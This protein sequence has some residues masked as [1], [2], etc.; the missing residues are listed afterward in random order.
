MVYAAI[1]HL[2]LGHCEG[3]LSQQKGLSTANEE[4]RQG[5]CINGLSALM[6]DGLMV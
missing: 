5:R 4:G 2:L 3:L 1:G 6:D